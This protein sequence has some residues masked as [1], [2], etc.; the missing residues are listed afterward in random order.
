MKNF[1]ITN[2]NWILTGVI[3]LALV[4]LVVLGIFY[5]N[6]ESDQDKLADTRVEKQQELDSMES[7]VVDE[8]ALLAEALKK[9]DETHAGFPADMDSTDLLSLILDY[10]R[11]THVDIQPL[12]VQP[13]GEIE[14]AG[15]TY[16]SVGFTAT[17]SGSLP[18]IMAFINK[19]ENG[20]ISTFSVSGI[21]L[22]GSGGNWST[23]M[24]ASVI[25]T[26]SSA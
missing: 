16:I 14:I 13:G 21:N 17:V 24:S 18:N 12:T 7:D 26:K 2:I 25:S 1:I 11:E 10:Q 8:D 5:M 19:L 22:S 3:V 4:G 23:S 20:D 9:L 6:E 15:Q